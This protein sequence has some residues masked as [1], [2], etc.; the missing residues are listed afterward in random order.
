MFKKEKRGM[1]THHNRYGDT[2]SW[3]VILFGQSMKE[4]PQTWD[5]LWCKRNVPDFYKLGIHIKI[6]LWNNSKQITGGKNAKIYF[7]NRRSCFIIR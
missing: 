7:C 2:P 3:L 4:C 5:S 6:A 1:V